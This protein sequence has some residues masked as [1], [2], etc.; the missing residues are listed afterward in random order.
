M[1]DLPTLNGPAS[2][3]QRFD[4]YARTI[5]GIVLRGIEHPSCELK[6]TL[7]LDRGELGDRLDFVKLL[8]GLA[9]AHSDSECLIVIGADQNE[10]KFF[11]VANAAEFDP[12]RVS[13]ILAKYLSPEPK[14]E[15]FNNMC[16]PGGEHYVLIV[17][18]R[19][20]PRPIMTTID[21][22]VNGKVRFRPGDIWIKD[23]TRLRAVSRADLDLMYQPRIEQE[24]AKR[25]RIIFE[26]LK[27][28]LG[29]ELLSQAVTS[30]P[31]PELLVGSRKRLARFAEAMI[32][33]ADPSRFKMLIEMARQVLVEKWRTVL[34]GT[35]SRYV[36]SDAE[37]EA[38]AGF[39]KNEFVPTLTSLVDLGIEIIRFDAPTTWLGFVANLLVEAF[40]TSRQVEHLHAVN[41]AGDNS[42]P[43]ARPAYEVYLGARVIATYAI[44]RHR[45]QFLK[46]IMPRYVT[47]LSSRHSQD[48]L[49]PMLFWPFSGDLDLPDMKAGRNEEYWRQ[50]IEET[51][52]EDFGSEEEFL[53]AAA[54]LEFL[55]ELNSYLLIQY[56]SPATDALRANSPEKRTAYI[57][58]FWN[59]PLRVA[60]PTA[61]WILE[62]LVDGKGFPHDVAIEP[63]ITSAIFDQMPRKDREVFFG[64]F[65][66]RTKTWQDQVMMQQ[67]RSPFLLSWPPRLQAAVDAYKNC[68]ASQMSRS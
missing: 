31:A 61:S 56:S 21:G 50:R 62:S 63:Q 8:Q 11:D 36:I 68:Q 13:P 24:A 60:I 39:Y 55:L 25:A 3:P 34:Q 35:T 49:E 19:A 54:Q 26:H 2:L 57:P 17:L 66:E 4:E 30:T 5:E 46:E 20:Q 40:D 18:N 28:D 33:S 27:A 1:P 37:K 53:I 14:I 41:Q 6:R 23:N 44:F 64:E 38:V 51:W 7:T 65:L 43:F 67:S 52:G 10:R 32:S 22:E 29:P 47:P 45:V 12:A 9:N 59:T 42:V 48:T 15:I 58:D 16:A